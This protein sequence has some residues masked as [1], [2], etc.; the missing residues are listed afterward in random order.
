LDLLVVADFVLSETAAMADVVLPVT[1]WAEEDGT[2]TNLE[3]RVLRRHRAAPP[4]EGVRTDLEVLQGLAI[5]LGQ[6]VSRFPT[7]PS[8]VFNELRAA[9]AG[10]PADYAGISYSRLDAGE[11]LHW[12]CS[13]GDHPGTPRLFQHSFAHPDGRARFVPVE[14]AQPAEPPSELFPLRGTTGRLLAHYQSGAQTRRVPELAAAA[15]DMFVEVHP[16]TAARAGLADGDTARV[17]SARGA[18]TALVRTV[19]TA[20]TD[21][22]FLPFHFPG[23]ARANLLTNPALDPTSRMPEFKVCAVRL[24]AAS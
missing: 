14:P 18:V 13:S 12:P 16:D 21:T 8:A 1:Q 17:V 23:D 20:R 15:G 22:V 24:E 3:G 4:P 19:P 6:P 7:D 5:R 11:E 9:S 10:G 2:M